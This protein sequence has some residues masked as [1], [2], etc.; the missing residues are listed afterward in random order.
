MLAVFRSS[1]KNEGLLALTPDL[2]FPLGAAYSLLLLTKLAY[3]NFGADGGLTEFFASPVRFRQIVMGKNP[4]HAA[5]FALEV[6]LVWLGNLFALPP[7]IARRKHGHTGG[8]LFVVPIDLAAGN[9]F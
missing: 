9:L 2:T 6:G 4:A 3:N 7:A 5:L 1:G 8:H